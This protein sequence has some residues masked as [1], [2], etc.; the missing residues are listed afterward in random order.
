MPVEVSWL[1]ENRVVYSRSFGILSV[2]QVHEAAA[3]STQMMDTGTKFV[4]LIANATDVEK[5]SF[6][7]ADIA[8]S[9]RGFPTSPNMGWTLTVSSN[10]MHRFFASIVVQMGSSRQRVFNTLEEAIAF[11]QSVDE[12]LPPI[13]IPSKAGEK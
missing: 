5:F 2:S 1:V 8:R 10:T 4:H 7:L 9:F 13:P 3:Q 12:T 6:S 11:L